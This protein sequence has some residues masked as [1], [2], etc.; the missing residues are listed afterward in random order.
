M[1]VVSGRKLNAGIS[2]FHSFLSA[3]A[4]PRALNQVP[5]YLNVPKLWLKSQMQTHPFPQKGSSVPLCL[6]NKD[7]DWPRNEECN[8]RFSEKQEQR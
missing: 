1:G 5:F 4:L 6:S 8:P 3:A 2:S 7:G